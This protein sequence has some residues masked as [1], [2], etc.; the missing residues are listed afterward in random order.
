MR[1]SAPFGCANFPSTADF[2]VSRHKLALDANTIAT[3]MSALPIAR[4]GRGRQ[5]RGA[6]QDR[7]NQPQKALAG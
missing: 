6:R 5:N 2:L 4:P 7:N 1:I 3:K